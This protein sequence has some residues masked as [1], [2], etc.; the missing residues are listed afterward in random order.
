MRICLEKL[1]FHNAQVVIAIHTHT[2][3]RI[4]TRTHTYTQRQ[5]A[6]LL[7]FNGIFYCK[8]YS[9]I[10]TFLWSPAPARLDSGRVATSTA[11]SRR[12]LAA[13]L[14]RIWAKFLITL[15]L[16]PPPPT[17]APAAVAAQGGFSRFFFEQTQFLICLQF[18][19]VF[20]GILLLKISPA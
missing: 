5:L 20:R 8:F 10:H 13:V 7:P 16:H 2:H 19:W 14:K 12:V 17:H 9:N 4:H 3:A 18:L 15:S 6:A 1:V 11:A